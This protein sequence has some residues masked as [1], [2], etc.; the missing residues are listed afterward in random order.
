MSTYGAAA[1]WSMPSSAEEHDVRLTR[2]GRLA[3]TA[4]I[5]TLLVALLLSVTQA[6]GA[7]RAL[8]DDSSSPMPVTT[9]SV[10]VV[11]GDSLWGIA[12]RVAPGTDPREV[13]EG[14]RELN[15]MRSN[16][17]QPGEVLLVPNAT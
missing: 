9:L 3:R 12:E 14:I 6:L 16:R 11:Q 7:G 2:R 4:A 15:A 5:A 10:V 17:I 8:A 1:V 13:I